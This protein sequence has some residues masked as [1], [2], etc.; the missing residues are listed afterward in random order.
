MITINAMFAGAPRPL[1]PREIQ[2]AIHKDA[3]SGPWTITTRGL[4]GDTQAD[5]KNHGGIDKALHHYPH[6]HYEAWAKDI[7]ELAQVL[8]CLPAFGENISTRGMTEAIVCVGDVYAVGAV[9]LQIAQG[10]QPCWKLNA[11]FGIQDM[12]IRVQ[13]TGR[14]GWYY[15]VLDPG[16]IEPGAELRL[17]DRPQPDWPLAKVIDLLYTRTNAFDQ[18]AALA[19]LP[20]LAPGWRNL[21]A[22]RVASRQVESWSNRL[23]GAST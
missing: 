5:T 4:V 12:A 1:G 20:E 14:T 19:D 23:R 7:P 2:S 15:R 9:R 21:A 16:L 13:K 10:R 22:R 6:E 17:I 11:R 18:L 3:I 8:T